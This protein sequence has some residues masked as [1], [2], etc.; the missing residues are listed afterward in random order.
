MFDVLKVISESERLKTAS[1]L[2]I[3]F[4]NIIA[5][6]AYQDKGAVFMLT[7]SSL[8]CF[9][10]RLERNSRVFFRIVVD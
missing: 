8:T 6:F 1:F 9:D 2:A 10:A 7:L 4:V 3:S 5:R